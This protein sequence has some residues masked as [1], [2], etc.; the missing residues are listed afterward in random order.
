MITKENASSLSGPLMSHRYDANLTTAERKRH[1]VFYT[2]EMIT[3]YLIAATNPQGPVADISCGDGAFLTAA[4]L[5]G[6]PVMGIDRD[7]QALALA[8]THLAH[9]PTHCRWL[10]LGDGLTPDLPWT[11][12]VVVGNPPYLEAKKADPA[13]K[14]RCRALFPEIARGG[15][16]AYIFFL[17]AGLHLLPHGGRLGYII[18]NKFLVSDYA[19]PLR[20]ELLATTTIEEII[21]VSDIPTFRDAAVYPILLILRKMAPTEGHRVRTGA[22]ND[23]R[24][25]E[26]ST[27]PDA[28]IAQAVWRETPRHIIWL[29]PAEPAA[30]GIVDRL[31]RDPDARRLGELL[32]L[33]WTISF[34]RRGL[35][36]DFIFPSSTGRTPRPFLG[37][38]RFNGNADVCRYRT[39]WSGWWIDYDED[40]ART[41]GNQ[42]PPWS[43]FSGPKLVI[44]QNARRI[45]ATLDNDNFACKD[46]FLVGRLRDGASRLPHMLQDPA[47]SLIYLLGIVN[48][49]LLSYLYS[50][51]FKATHVGGAYLHYLACYLQELPIRLAPDMRPIASLVTRLLDPSLAD[52]A[53]VETDAALDELVFDLYALSP[54]ERLVVR[55]AVPY[56]WGEPGMRRGAWDARG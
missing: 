8:E 3:H 28:T 36:D 4:A 29:P 24:Q 14:A 13:L 12:D 37:G 25:L 10:C 41:V 39:A 17:K 30:R 44:A 11:P 22:V 31:T 15:F 42:L 54:A 35:R 34:H 9:L 55:S 40:R 26:H 23:L 5:R 47:V 18:P 19:R 56:T 53:R 1:G 49:S 7:P 51:L 20:E 38:K 43:L 16:D 21:D 46:T 45:L 50:I 2:P 6:V 52:D 33:R 48:S 32:D 27:F